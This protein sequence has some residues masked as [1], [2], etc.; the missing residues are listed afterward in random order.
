MNFLKYLH[1]ERRKEGERGTY[2]AILDMSKGLWEW[3][4]W[5]PWP[6]GTPILAKEVIY[7]KVN[8]LINP[9]E[10]KVLYKR[11]HTQPLRHLG[12]QH[13]DVPRTLPR[14][15]VSLA[16]GTLSYPASATVSVLR[17]TNCLPTACFS[18]LSLCLHSLPAPMIS[19]PLKLHTTQFVTRLLQEATPGFSNMQFLPSCESFTYRCNQT[20]SHILYLLSQI[21]LKPLQIFLI[22]FLP[23]YEPLEDAHHFK[24]TLCGL[25]SASHY[26][27]PS[28]YILNS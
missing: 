13:Q 14:D 28:K 24:Y 2:Q 6:H 15:T 10:S 9:F 19:S 4:R 26:T 25:K 8:S 23:N 21:M 12:Q 5:G 7:N 3:D 22:L 17:Y 18:L 16:H 27:G 1:R 20:K 11:S